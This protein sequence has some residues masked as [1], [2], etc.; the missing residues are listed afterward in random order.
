MTAINNPPRPLYLYDSTAYI[1]AFSAQPSY[2]SDE[3]NLDITGYNWES[4]RREVEKFFFDAAY[5]GKYELLKKKNIS[6][7]LM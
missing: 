3:V 4:R 1:S 6:F 7:V 2:L 5:D